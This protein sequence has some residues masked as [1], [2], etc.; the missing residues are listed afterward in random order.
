MILKVTPIQFFRQVRQEV[1]KI[2]WPSRKEVSQVTM[3]VLVIVTLA[4]AFFFAVDV[5]LA[6]LVEF[7]LGLCA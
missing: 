3:I 7:I 5:V 2:T 4:A 1:K 6:G